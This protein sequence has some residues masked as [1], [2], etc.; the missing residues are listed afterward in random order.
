M[1]C[2]EPGRNEILNRKHSKKTIL[3]ATKTNIKNNTIF[4]SVVNNSRR[5]SSLVSSAGRLRPLPMQPKKPTIYR[6]ALKLISSSWPIS[7]SQRAK[8]RKARKP[9]SNATEKQKFSK[10]GGGRSSSPTRVKCSNATIFQC[11]FLQA[12]F[13][14]FRQ[15][16]KSPEIEELSLPPT[17]LQCHPRPHDCI[18]Q[19][20]AYI[21]AIC[22]YSLKL[23]SF[24][25]RTYCTQFREQA[26][27][28]NWDKL[29]PGTR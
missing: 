14:P 13:V 20:C 3:C 22:A 2:I 12:T 17:V 5:F 23:K 1:K 26:M 24:A 16:L 21:H 15:S 18:T 10:S 28:L 8:T 11:K 27:T 7:Y 4:F 6:E 25:V 29:I 19:R 9:Q